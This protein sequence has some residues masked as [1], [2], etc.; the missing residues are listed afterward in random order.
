MPQGKAQRKRRPLAQPKPTNSGR[1]SIVVRHDGWS[2][3]RT[4]DTAEEATAWRDNMI[5]ERK[6]G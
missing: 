1:W 3:K 2:A 4:F 5:K 6:N